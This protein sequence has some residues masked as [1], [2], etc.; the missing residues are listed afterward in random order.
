MGILSEPDGSV[1]TLMVFSYK[2]GLC[3]SN[4]VIAVISAVTAKLDVA[5]LHYDPEADGSV[6]FDCHDVLL[7]LPRLSA[8]RQR[9]WLG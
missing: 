5:V 7:R 1:W 3:A 4:E 8:Q 6:V 9:R 2:S